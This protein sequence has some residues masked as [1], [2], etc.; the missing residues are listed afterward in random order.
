MG[1]QE[2]KKMRITAKCGRIEKML[3]FPIPGEWEDWMR[4]LSAK[5]SEAVSN[6]K[7]PTSDTTFEVDGL[8]SMSIKINIFKYEN[9]F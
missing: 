9:K 3:T 1:K 4:D 5:M 2:I 8:R 7:T 6:G